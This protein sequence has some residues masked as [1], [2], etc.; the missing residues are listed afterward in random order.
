MRRLQ[1]AVVGFGRLGRACVNEVRANVDL[2]LVGVVRRSGSPSTLPAPLGGV[3]V[4]GH[5]RDLGHV[6]ATLLCVPPGVATDIAREILQ[7]RSAI[8]ECAQLQSDALE[9]H[10]AAI[11][12]AARNHRVPAVIGAGWNPGILPLFRYAFEI[13]VPRGHTTLSARPGVNLHHA[14]AAKNLPGVHDALVAELRDAEGRMKRYVYAQLDAGVDP[15]G[16]EAAL[17]AD[18]LF[19]GEESLLF[20]VD[21]TAALEQEVNGV[22]LERRG[23]A[24]SGAHQNLLLEARFEVETFAARA[25]LDAARRLDQLKPGAHLYTIRPRG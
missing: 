2:E 23:S 19:A 24:A 6:D 16:V 13:L 7:L 22:L 3:A 1:I 12:A 14:E 5:L 11:A 8:V 20:P 9:R 21:S 4:T 15:A 25:M 17:A 18:P 10:Y